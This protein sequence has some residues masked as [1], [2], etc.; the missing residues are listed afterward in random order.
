MSLV[1][2]IFPSLLL[3]FALV[4]PL[5][6]QAKQRVLSLNDVTASPLSLMVAKKIDVPLVL[7]LDPAKVQDSWPMHKKYAVADWSSFVSRDLKSSMENYFSTVTVLAPGDAM[8]DGP[9]LVADVKID[10]VQLRPI[11][12]GGLTYNVMQMQ[13]GFA[14]RAAG[15]EDYLFSFAGTASSKETYASALD[16]LGQLIESAIGGLLQAWTEKDVPTA[17][18][19]AMVPAK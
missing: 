10:R 17:I 14:V 18:R 4:A 9:H 6:V 8:P 15:A 11:E 19:G 1:H 16:G 13:W 3:G 7:V 2:R 12:T 5:G